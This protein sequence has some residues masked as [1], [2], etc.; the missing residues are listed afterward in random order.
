MLV[1]IK[2]LQALVAKLKNR[3]VTKQTRKLEK[4]AERTDLVHELCIKRVEMAEAIKQ[5]LEDRAYDKLESDVNA[6]EAE[7]KQAAELLEEV[8]KL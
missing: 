4:C 5:H 6:V 2:K 1:V 8:N 7:R 3:V